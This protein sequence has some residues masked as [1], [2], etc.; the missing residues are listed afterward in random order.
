[1]TFN[2]T[3][4]CHPLKLEYD[5]ETRTAHIFLPHGER[6]DMDGA[7]AMVRA[8]DATARDIYVYGGTRVMAVYVRK[9]GRT[10]F[11]ETR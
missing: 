6:T 11:V 7:V 2:D 1:M 9:K 10:E 5:F 4:R 8:I 3:L